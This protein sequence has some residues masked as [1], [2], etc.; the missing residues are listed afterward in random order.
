MNL[1]VTAEGVESEAEVVLLRE[2][3]CDE[4]QGYHFSRPVPAHELTVLLKAQAPTPK[5]SSGNA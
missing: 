1:A 3:Q 2:W 4:A 5:A